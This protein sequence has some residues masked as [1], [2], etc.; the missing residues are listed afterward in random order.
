MG[1]LTCHLVFQYTVELDCASVVQIYRV[2]RLLFIVSL[3]LCD[4][5]VLIYH[6]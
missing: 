5:R 1:G 4:S 3:F 6:S 2:N